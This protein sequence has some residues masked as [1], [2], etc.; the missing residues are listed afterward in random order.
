LVLAAN[1]TNLLKDLQ[2]ASEQVYS[3]IRHTHVFITEKTSFAEL[4]DFSLISV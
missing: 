3:F 4:P 1:I 2:L